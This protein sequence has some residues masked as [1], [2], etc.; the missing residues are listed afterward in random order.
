MKRSKL[1]IHTCYLLILIV[2]F[3]SEKIFS[4]N[5]D[6]ESSKYS[7]LVVLFKNWRDFEKPPLREGAPDYTANTFE[8]RDSEF[9]QLRERLLAIDTTGWS[10]E[11]QIDW[12]IVWAEM[13]GYEFNRK[14]LK[15][16]ER[17]PAF[18]SQSGITEVM[19]RL[20][21]ARLII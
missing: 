10:V 13:N 9:K 2:L 18:T 20:M 4:Q 1:I 12:M 3:S 8:K 6:I 16:W 5:T 19:F 14:I 7:S 17:D 11:N 15:P 21:K